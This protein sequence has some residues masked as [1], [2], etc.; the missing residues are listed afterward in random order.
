MLF[1]SSEGECG[2]DPIEI[3]SAVEEMLEDS[4]FLDALTYNVD[5]KV[6]MEKR[7]QVVMKKYKELIHVKQDISGRL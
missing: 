2:L 5:S 3:R 7:F 6:Q 1:R 4:I